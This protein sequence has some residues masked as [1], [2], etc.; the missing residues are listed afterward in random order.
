[1]DDSSMTEEEMLRAYEAFMLGSNGQSI[2][3]NPSSSTKATVTTQVGQKKKKGRK[4]RKQ[5]T[6]SSIRSPPRESKEDFINNQNMAS[7]LKI[8]KEI[9]GQFHSIC[10]TIQNHWIHFDDQLVNVVSSIENIRARVPT[11][12]KLIRKLTTSN[13][14]DSSTHRSFR[15]S[16]GFLNLEDIQLA[17]SHDLLQHEKMVAALRKL[18]SDLSESLQMIGRQLNDAQQ[19][20]QEC[21]YFLFGTRDQSILKT[22]EREDMSISLTNALQL[23][24]EMNDM[25][26]MLSRETYRKQCLSI[27]LID[28][29][30]DTLLTTDSAVSNKMSSN[31][32][33]KA[34]TSNVWSRRSKHSCLDTHRFE[35][36][37][38]KGKQH[39]F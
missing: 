34:V 8:E 31:G 16:T 12:M 1:M 2:E 13:K 19:H 26:H 17:L 10:K 25:Y 30:N 28:S 20:Y 39:S 11:E 29:I 15:E 23:V 33:P 21:S 18:I 35:A 24:D 7:I 36:Y 6:L 3:D 27:F 4:G 22:I 14:M 37:L 5:D 9:W 38:V 32:V